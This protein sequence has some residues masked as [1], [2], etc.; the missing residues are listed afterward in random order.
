MALL[1][2]IQSGGQ[3]GADRSALDWAINR[4]VPPKKRGW[5]RAGF[6]L[7][8]GPRLSPPTE[9]NVAAVEGAAWQPPPQRTGKDMRPAVG[10][11]SLHRRDSFLQDVW[12]S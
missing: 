4:G 9:R 12:T 3:T 10:A 2:K 1:A 8:A 11:R 6:A 7:I 5:K